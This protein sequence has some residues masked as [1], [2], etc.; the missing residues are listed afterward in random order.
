MSV[1]VA[2]FRDSLQNLCGALH[3]RFDA[4]FI[5]LPFGKGVIGFD[6]GIVPKHH[7]HG[8]FLRDTALW[9][10]DLTIGM[11]SDMIR[12]RFAEHQLAYAWFSATDEQSGLECWSIRVRGDLSNVVRWLTECGILDLHF[13]AGETNWSL[14]LNETRDAIV[15]RRNGEL[16]E[17]IDL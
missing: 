5:E 3:N 11:T 15:I 7:G 6:F 9:R 14:T 16:H 2:G 4:F 12:P 8:S 13:H 10:A 1:T 17:V